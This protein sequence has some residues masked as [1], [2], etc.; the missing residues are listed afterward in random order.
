VADYLIWAQART[1]VFDY[2]EL[3]YEPH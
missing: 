1:D 3:F 2:I